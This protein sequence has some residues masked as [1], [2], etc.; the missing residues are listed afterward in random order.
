MLGQIEFKSSK[1]RIFLLGEVFFNYSSKAFLEGFEG[2]KSRLGKIFQ[3]FR[4]LKLAG[5]IGIRRN[6]CK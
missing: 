5:L 6:T 1:F 3:S 4:I 2:T